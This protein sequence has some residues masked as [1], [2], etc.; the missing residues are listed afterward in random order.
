M[1]ICGCPDKTEYHLHSHNEMDGVAYVPVSKKYS[2]SIRSSDNFEGL[3]E[4]MSR[5]RRESTKLAP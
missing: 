5:A 2:I 4:S 3:R 1:C